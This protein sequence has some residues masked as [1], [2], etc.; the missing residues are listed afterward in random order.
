MAPMNH[1]GPH[2]DLDDAAHSAGSRRP[3]ALRSPT[4]RRRAL[5]LLGG[6]GLGVLAVACGT[7]TSSGS[8]AA[9]TTTSEG[10][11]TST[12]GSSTSAADAAACA[13]LPEETAGPYPADGTNGP[14]VLTTD[15]V[16]RND[17][18]TSFGGLSGTAEGVPLTIELTVVDT[19]AGCAP[20]A[21]A[22]VYLWHCDA[23]GD[24]SLYSA[25]L[26]DQNYLRGVQVADDDGRLGFTSIF[27]GC[28]S[29]RWPHIHFEVYETLSAATSG[30][31]AILTSQIALPGTTSDEVYVSGDYDGSEQNLSRITLESDNVFSDGADAQTPQVSGDTASGFTI[32]LT[33]G[34]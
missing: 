32:T 34:V 18:T 2:P 3:V 12:T 24:Y 14:N 4:S 20:L 7:T 23:V 6:G 9:S 17:I 15:G 30:R 25:G 1:D 31:N 11:T 16:V 10:A 28:Y 13:T 27:P 26:E 33:V 22:A 21:G 5:A 19:G 29:G 8:G